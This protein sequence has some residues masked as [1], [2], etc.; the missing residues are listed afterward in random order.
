MPS[1]LISIIITILNGA[2][3]LEDCLCSIAGQSFQ[4]F[5]LIIVD[6]GSTDNTVSILRQYSGIVG[7]LKVIPG[8]GLYAGLN[9]G[10]RLSHGNW[11]YFIGCDDQLYDANVLGKVASSM[12]HTDAMLI[13]GEVQHQDQYI[14]KP[15]FGLPHLLLH[16][17]HHQGIFYHKTVFERYHYNEQLK[18]AADYELNLR[19]AIDQ[20]KHQKLS[21][22]IARYG[23]NGISNREIG[24]YYEETQLIHKSIFSGLTRVWVI[25]TFWLKWKFWLLKYKMGLLG[26]AYKIKNQLKPLV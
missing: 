16:R 21:F 2:K 1:P 8:I 5:E 13:A 23:G 3:T 14:T 15:K 22:I 19:L 17:I 18:L 12:H 20:F 4:D 7:Q 9:E 6:G 11:L 10:V 24:T 26:L 25:V